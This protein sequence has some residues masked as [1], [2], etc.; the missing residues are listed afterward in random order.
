M[1]KSILIYN[2]LIGLA[3]G[4]SIAYLFYYH[5]TILNPEKLKGDEPQFVKEYHDYYRTPR[6]FQTI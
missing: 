4:L 2:F 6:G 1:S 5:P 3:I